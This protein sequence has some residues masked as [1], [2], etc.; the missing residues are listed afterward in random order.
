MIQLDLHLHT[1]TDCNLFC[2][3]CYNNSGEMNDRPKIERLISTIRLICASYHASI[4]LEGGEIF[5]RPDLLFK[6][7]DLPLEIL[8]S[9]TVTTNGTIFYDDPKIIHMLQ[10]LASLRVSIEGHTAALH[11]R[12]RGG[13]FE[14]ILNNAKKYQNLDVPVCLRITLNRL[15]YRGFI[16]N[17]I[18]SL[19]AKKFTRFQIYEF[20]SVGRGKNYASELSLN[21]PLNDLFQEMC[22]VR[23]PDVHLSMMFPYGRRQE[24]LEAKSALEKS[25]Y[26]VI[27]FLPEASVSIHADGSVYKCAWDND[28][29]NALC[30]WYHNEKNALQTLQNSNLI[31]SCEHCSAFCILSNNA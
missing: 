13:S 6:M 5:L 4:H 30:N 25:G 14:K 1:N 3:H 28:P 21:F 23:I 7:D 2:I 20:Q 27:T 15:N 31:H 16:E 22:E 8:K 9:I 12:I 17:T 19:A 18:C 11:E 29:R 10:S 26:Q 24:I